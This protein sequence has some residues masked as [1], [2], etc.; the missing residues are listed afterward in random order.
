MMQSRL[1]WH[2]GYGEFCPTPELPTQAASQL[3]PTPLPPC[4]GF[5]WSPD[6][7]TRCQRPADQTPEPQLNLSPMR[8]C[9]LRGSDV[10]KPFPQRPPRPK[11]GHLMD[12]APR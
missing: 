4:F 5:E 12:P 7:P 3:A 11:E 9:S 8:V 1:H 6:H 10:A 2:P